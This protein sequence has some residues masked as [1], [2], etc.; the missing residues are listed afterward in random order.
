MAASKQ[1]QDA[2]QHEDGGES[3]GHASGRR[4]VGLLRAAKGDLCDDDDQHQRKAA[5]HISVASR[6][7]S[8]G[9]RAGHPVEAF[10]LNGGHDPLA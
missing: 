2:G 7:A 3:P 6:P 8:P 10:A 1:S 5:G 4:I 9:R